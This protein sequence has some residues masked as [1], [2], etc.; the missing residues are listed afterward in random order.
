MFG[1]K[2]KPGRTGLRAALLAGASLIAFLAVS[3]VGASSAFALGEPCS[4]TEIN[5]KGASLQKVAQEIWT[6]RKVG[7]FAEKSQYITNEPA[8]GFD[9]VCPSGPGTEAQEALEPKVTYDST[10]SGPGLEAWGANS[11]TFNE[12]EFE[13]IASDD[14]PNAAQ[15]ANI[16]TAT[17]EEPLVIPVTQT[18]IAIP[19]NP[20]K[21]CTVHALTWHLIATM[22]RGKITT[23][24]DLKDY[25]TNYFEAHVAGA[26]DKHLVRVVRQEASGTTF[27]FKHFLGT[28][29]TTGEPL[30][31]IGGTWAEL[32]PIGPG[33]APNTSWPESCGGT[34]LT[35]VITA[36]GGGG[37]VNTVKAT[38]G[39]VGYA[40]YPDA[41][42]AGATVPTVQNGIEPVF[43][44]HPTFGKINDVNG[45]AN[46]AKAEYSFPAGVTSHE[47]PEAETEEWTTAGETTRDWSEVY[48]SNKQIGEITGDDTYPICTL[49]YVIALEDSSDVFGTN[50]ATT[51]RDYLKYVISTEIVGEAEEEVGGQVD[52]RGNFYAPLPHG[53]EI[54]ATH[55]VG[56]IQ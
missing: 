36:A 54:A 1:F 4:G 14:P 16:A 5:G 18:A 45:N 28:V 12:P 19:I 22:F 34:T 41:A 53:P 6:G 42:K 48:G 23:W 37:V 8:T 24:S 43:P 35:E 33:G 50:A 20:P 27:Q 44:F 38:E 26:C 51:L 11:G 21:D 7:P 25:S 2:R 55:A 15:L 29:D 9:V 46:C 30:P 49:T 39:S 47:G 56:L 10:G 17:N 31:C 13:F 40:A 3:G 32:Q 52:V